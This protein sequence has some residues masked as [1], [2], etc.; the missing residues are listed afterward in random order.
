MNTKVAAVV[1]TIVTIAAA[2][3]SFFSSPD[4]LQETATFPA[5]TMSTIRIVLG[6][7]AVVGAVLTGREY[8]KTSKS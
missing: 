8:S 5:S 1:G 6:I 7:I 4:Y 2:L 3:G